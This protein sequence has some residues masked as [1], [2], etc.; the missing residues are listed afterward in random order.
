[1]VIGHLAKL[2][3]K[4]AL[5]NKDL[6]LPQKFVHQAV[7][8]VMLFQSGQAHVLSEPLFDL[9]YHLGVRI[10]EGLLTLVL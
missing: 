1:M 3:Q 6:S 9:E 8:L 4:L 2:V 7:Q 10:I 5:I